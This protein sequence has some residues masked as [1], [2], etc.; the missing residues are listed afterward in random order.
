MVSACR[1]QPEMF[2]MPDIPE[3]QLAPGIDLPAPAVHEPT[4]SPA[5]VPHQD[6]PPADAE[7]INAGMSTL[8]AVC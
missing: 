2:E 5:Q 8:Y 3:D 6:D 7:D 4:L 1:G